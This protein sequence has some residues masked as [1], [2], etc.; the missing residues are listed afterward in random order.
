MLFGYNVIDKI[1][2]EH[3]SELAVI[4]N[5]QDTLV[6]LDTNILSYMYKLH[7]AARQEFFAWTDSIVASDR[8]RIPAWCAG[9]YFAR[10][11]EGQLHSYTPKSRDEDQPLRALKAMLDTASMFV[12]EGLL[13]AI[14]FQGDRTAYL[15]QFGTAIGE[16]KKFTRAFKHQFDPQ[17]IH[18]EI[19]Q[20]L[21]GVILD[22]DLSG[23][24]GRAAKEGA[25]RIEHRL[26]PA[27]RDESKS[28]NRLGDL[29]IWFEILESS[30][31]MKDR[32][33]KVLFLTNDEKSDW[34]Y[35]P[36]KRMEIANGNRKAVPNV[37]P[38]LKVIDPR[39]VS[40]FRRMVG[41]ESIAICSLLSLVEGLSKIHPTNVRQL[42]AAIQI[43]LVDNGSKPSDAASMETP[44][45]STEA[46]SS[47]NFASPAERP[48]AAATP[49]GQEPG[50]EQDGPGNSG[51]PEP[52]PTAEAVADHFAF[53]EDGYRDAAYEADAPGKIN[54][55]IRALKSHNWYTQNPAVEEIKA[56]RTE[57]F[58][59][60]AWFVLGRNIYQ[61]ACG[62]AQKAMDF[63]VNLDIQLKRFPQDTAQYIL[64]GIVFEIYF[65]SQ[66]EFRS[67]A[68]LAYLDK[69][70]SVIAGTDYTQVRDS[71]GQSCRRQ[72]PPCCSCRGTPRN[73]H[74][75]SFPVT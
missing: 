65:D 49:L 20:H 55:I 32:F 2:D 72:M 30:R 52:Q 74:F 26:P 41:H 68:K 19:Q 59:P 46:N 64:C 56:I 14:E 34:V 48:P 38:K 58:S 75:V 69:S 24:C 25:S 1:K 44:V 54:E 37:D 36:L 67:K 33:C 13:K 61:A 11:R 47:E 3:L 17:A 9:E 63:M 43:Y 16:L 51:Q 53:D 7:T 70:L 45:M 71:S 22:S 57:S 62:N 12:D 15:T 5:S 21:G 40:E 28:E 73:S 10:L 4:A 29:I 50:M 60:T 27:F 35:A 18:E 39:L 66:G 23:L 42:A 8:L 6:F 31:E